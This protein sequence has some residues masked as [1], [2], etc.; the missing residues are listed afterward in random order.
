MSNETHEQTAHCST[1]RTAEAQSAATR[2][3]CIGRTRL[4]TMTNNDSTADEIEAKVVEI[5]E[6][7][8]ANEEMLDFHESRLEDLRKRRDRL[9]DVFGDQ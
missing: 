8:T 2:T 7:I 6:R 1:A 3:R 5:D 9:E 4:K